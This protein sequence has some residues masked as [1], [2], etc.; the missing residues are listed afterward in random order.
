MPTPLEL[1]A[2]ELKKAGIPIKK[3]VRVIKSDK[4]AAPWAVASD[5]WLLRWARH[6]AQNYPIVMR[7]DGVRF[8]EGAASGIPAFVVGIGPSLDENIEELKAAHRRAIIIATDAAL[9]PLLSKGIIPDIAINFDCQKNQKTLWEGLPA[10]GVP[11]IA[12]SCTHPDTIA[13]YPGPL[14]FYNQWHKKDVFIERLLPYTFPHIGDIP[15]LGTVGNMG[16][17]LAAKMGCSPIFTAGMD[18][19]YQQNGAGWKYRCTDYHYGPDDMGVLTWAKQVNKTLYDNDDRV[20]RSFE[21]KIGTATYRV[22]PELDAYQECLAGLTDGLHMKIVDCSP[23][24]LLKE[25][26]RNISITQAINESCINEQS[27]G[28]TTLYHLASITK[29]GRKQWEEDRKNGYSY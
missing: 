20:R 12:S 9:R 3:G 17:M 13:T 19:C 7:S 6:A 5:T 24:G 25:Y 26:F 8:L 16:I 28:R 23:G 18:L 4:K 21:K 10:A 15:S 14:L 1:Q 11:M 27:Q 22:D 29:N 2:E